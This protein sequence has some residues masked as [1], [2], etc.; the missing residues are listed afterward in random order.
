MNN[1]S[2]NV[3]LSQVAPYIEALMRVSNLDINQSKTIVYYCVFTWCPNPPYKPLLNLDGETGTGKNRI[4]EQIKNWC[5]S[6]IWI[7]A[8]NATPAT[9]RDKLA[10][11]GTAFIEEVD[12]VKEPKLECEIWLKMRY[13]STSSSVDYRAQQVNDQRGNVNRMVNTNHFGYTVMHTQ[14]PFQSIEL[15]RRIIQVHI[16]K[17]TD[18]DYTMPRT[19]LGNQVLRGI[20]QVIPWNAEVPGSGSAF[21]CWLP[22]LRVGGYLA[23]NEFVNYAFNCIEEKTEETNLSK[24]FEPQGIVLSEIIPRY[25]E[26]LRRNKIKLPITE[27][28]AAIRDRKVQFYPDE[29]Q[30][31]K[32]A[33]RL[34]F[35][36]YH[37]NNK[38]HIKVSTRENLESI[39]IANDISTDVLNDDSDS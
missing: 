35:A 32:F 7:K 8:E 1:N 13:D 15:D 28:T 9:F 23:D 20:A 22:L 14:N 25:L 37:P 17:N 38:A 21:D 3:L 36:V 27:V 19:A 29:R 6:P 39:L 10:G 12:K 30:V 11:S 31:T 18:R 16:T 33:K 4:M 24:V 34:G 5:Y 2:T 26:C